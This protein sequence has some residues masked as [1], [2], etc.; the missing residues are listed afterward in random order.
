VSSR[1]AGQR[2]FSD[3]LSAKTASANALSPFP[4][5]ERFQA[6]SFG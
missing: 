3:S 4:I 6:S 5:T 2:D 1:L